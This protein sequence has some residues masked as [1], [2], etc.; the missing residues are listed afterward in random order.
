MSSIFTIVV[1]ATSNH[2]IAAPLYKY[3]DSFFSGGVDPIWPHRVL[4]GASILASIAVGIGIIK[5]A[6]KFWSLTTLLVSFGVAIEAICTLLLFGFDEGVSGVQQSRIDAQN[7][8]IIVLEKQLLPRSLDAELFAKLMSGAP[9]APLTIIYPR[10]DLECWWLAAAI[11]SAL[12]S[13]LHWNPE[14]PMP[15]WG[16][17]GLARVPYNEPTLVQWGGATVGITI[18][19]NSF[20]SE[21]E[22][23][24]EKSSPDETIKGA[25]LSAYSALA[26][27]LRW[28]VN[29][30][31]SADDIIPL[32]ANDVPEGALRLVVGPRPPLLPQQLKALETPPKQ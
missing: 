26:R 16:S 25:G 7:A 24:A 1:S 21:A 11:Y 30:A 8:E 4:I 29:G 18:A 5:E 6:K 32:P 14:F 19:M 23:K 27:A 12:R 28:S 3:F 13:K 2:A 9:S 31:N 17:R 20:P 10:D 15:V 22:L